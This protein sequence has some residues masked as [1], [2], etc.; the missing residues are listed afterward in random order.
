MLLEVGKRFAPLAPTGGCSI[1]DVR[2][3]AAGIL[4]ASE[5]G[6]TGANY[7]LGG[8]NLSYFEIW[9]LFARVG[10]SRP[11]VGRLGPVIKFL[12]GRAGD[13]WG[14]LAGSEPPVNSAA[15]AMS[16]QTHYYS[17][18]RAKSELGYRRRPLEESV[19][20]AWQWFREH[21]YV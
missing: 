15:L 13:L 18:E 5:R 2:D 11:P 17:S 6:R 10:G 9:Q 4:A 20:D 14:R 21:G 12:A 1:C 7:I 8:E 16:S 19:R 3:V